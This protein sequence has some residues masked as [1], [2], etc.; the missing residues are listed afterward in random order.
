MS[1]TVHEDEYKSAE[2]DLEQ[3][4]RNVRRESDEGNKAPLGKYTK[5]SQLFTPPTLFTAASPVSAGCDALSGNWGFPSPMSPPNVVRPFSSYAQQNNMSSQI[6]QNLRIPFEHQPKTV[7]SFLISPIN[8]NRRGQNIETQ[9]SVDLRRRSL[10]TDDHNSIDTNGLSFSERNTISNISISKFSNSG[11][12]SLVV[13][14]TNNSFD[15]IQGKV[16]ETAKDQ[17]GCRFLQRWLEMNCN[18]EAVQALMSEII[19]HVG[20]LMMDQYANFLL[21]K[22][23]DVMPRDVRLKVAK[24]AA[25][26]IASIAMTAHG[27]FS[28]QKMIETISCPEEMEMIREA[29]SEDVV[30][31]VKD[32]HGNHVIQKVLN[33]FHPVDKQFIYDA[34]SKDCVG[35]ATNK[36]GCCVLQRCLEYASPSQK[37]ALVNHILSCCL[38]IVQDPFGNYVLQYVLDEND[39]KINDTIAIAFLPHVVHLCINKFSSNVMEK[40]LRGA[41]VQIQE[42]YVERMCNRDIVTRLIQDDFGNY[43]LQTALMISNPVQAENLVVAI[44]PLLHLIKNAPYAKKLE[45]KID[46]ILKRSEGSFRQQP[47][48]DEGVRVIPSAMSEQKRDRRENGYDNM[49]N[50][51]SPTPWIPL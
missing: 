46:S 31:L 38:E 7:D 29:L 43:V 25:P 33:R 16:Y 12:P 51:S 42:T 50:Q 41:S 10:A 19:P 48:F 22:L 8:G 3:I 17:H 37:S 20:E 13:P 2:P 4:L 45:S 49:Y 11:A 47:D 28:V 32:A 1:W 23:F 14:T 39:S 6:P 24:V 44:R 5:S 36:Q 26:K 27:T 21:Q 40:V 9:G 18:T 15:A 34:V 35:I 30:R